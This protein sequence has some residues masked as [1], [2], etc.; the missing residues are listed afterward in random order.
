MNEPFTVLIIDPNA[1]DRSRYRQH[2]TN[3]PRHTYQIYEAESAAEG[4]SLLPICHPDVVILEFLLPDMTGVDLI[5]AMRQDQETTIPTVMLTNHGTEETAVQA[6]KQGAYDYM[7][8]RAF[9]T[10][11]FDHALNS[12]IRQCTLE[13][14]LRES[15]EQQ[16]LMATTALRIRQSLDLSQILNTAVAEVQ[17]LLRCDR[18]LVYQFAPDGNGRVVAESIAPGWKAMVG[19]VI[20]DHCLQTPAMRQSYLQGRQQAIANIH[21]AELSG[22]HRRLL[23]QCK[24]KASLAVP[25]LF[26]ENSSADADRHLWGL[27]IAHHCSAARPWRNQEQDLLNALAVQLS[28][29]IQHGE[30]LQRHQNSLAKERELSAFK[31]RIITTVSHEYRT[32]LTLILGGAE[33]LER[34]HDR[35]DEAKK[36][37]YVRQIHQAATH[38]TDLVNDLLF[39]SQVELARLRFQ[40]TTLDLVD[41]VADLVAEHQQIAGEP[42]QLQFASEGE[43]RL[44][45]GDSSL[46]RQ[47]ISNLLSNAVKYSP[48]GGKIEI[49][50]HLQPQ[51]VTLSV[52]DYGIGIPR[53]DRDRLFQ[54]FGRASNVGTIP[55]TGLGLTIV[56][57]CVQMHSGQI[58]IESCEH[59]GTQVIIQLPRP[60]GEA[61][62]S[63]DY[64]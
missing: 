19:Q 61:K 49:D 7:S 3:H 45:C 62:A 31:S 20:P 26:Q 6:L 5:R 42:Y 36:L 1:E 28:I 24:V 34:Y 2:L 35:F 43:P 38:M 16:R 44:F 59:Q 30:L 11:R 12:A 22:R 18:V 17:Q 48:G 63:C 15:Q 50:L 23:E 56:Q 64:E 55:G 46:L 8:K 10:E 51:Q 13:H 21:E 52:K 14:L 57:S 9:Q 27:L 39:A 4:L 40:P 60:T 29:G 54:A 37:K 53:G 33:L 25:L 41:F 47:L 58:A 32:P